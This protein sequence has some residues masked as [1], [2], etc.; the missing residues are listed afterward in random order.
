L[1]YRS[2]VGEFP[3]IGSE[4]CAEASWAAGGLRAGRA[5][6]DGFHGVGGRIVG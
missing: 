6:R 4:D 1:Y 5:Y 3:E 2:P